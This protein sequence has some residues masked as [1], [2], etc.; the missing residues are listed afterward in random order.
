MAWRTVFFGLAAFIAS[1]FPTPVSAEPLP[2]NFTIRTNQ[3]REIGNVYG[4]STLA[5]L[6]GKP[7]KRDHSAGM[8][9]ADVR[10]HVENSGGIGFNVGGGYRWIDFDG[11]LGAWHRNRILGLHG[12]FDGREYHCRNG[13]ICDVDHFYW[14]NL[15]F[16]SLGSEWDFRINGYL[17]AGDR[18][19]E[20]M[21]EAIRFTG[22]NLIVAPFYAEAMWG[23][24]GEF[25]RKLTRVN[26][27]IKRR[28]NLDPKIY[29]AIGGYHFASRHGKDA[30]GVRF[31]LQ[32]NLHSNVTVGLR[33][34]YDSRFGGLILGQVAFA[35]GIPPR[36]TRLGPDDGPSTAIRRL[37]EFRQRQEL[38]V[39]GEGLSNRERILTDASG[40]PVPFVHV[41][42]TTG[43]GGDG[44]F[45]RPYD[46]LASVNGAGSNPGDTIVV[47]GGDGTTT[48]YDQGVTLKN[49]QS[50]IGGQ[51]L[52]MFTFG[53][54][55]VWSKIDLGRPT[56][57]NVNVGNVVTLANRNLVQGLDIVNAVSD[58]TTSGPQFVNGHGIFGSSV[59]DVRIVDV[60]VTGNDSNGILLSGS[61]GSILIDG[62]TCARNGA[63]MGGL[64]I[65][66]CID[67]TSAL[68]GDLNVTIQNSRVFDNFGDGIE[69]TSVT[70]DGTTVATIRDN[71]VFNNSEAG[72][73]A[74][75]GLDANAF[76]AVI[77]G[78]E[79]YQNA[80]QGL[81]A[82]TFAGARSTNVMISGN[83]VRANGFA[84]WAA[85][86]GIS[87]STGIDVGPNSA[88]FYALIEN[89]LVEGNAGNG[90]RVSS[91]TFNADASATVI[92][93]GNTVVGNG[94][95]YA[96]DDRAHGIL[97]FATASGGFTATYSVWLD[98]NTIS[99]NAGLAYLGTVLG[100][101]NP[102][103]TSGC[104]RLTGNTVG[105]GYVVS[106]TGGLNIGI[107]PFP[108]S[109]LATQLLEPSTNAVVPL[110][111]ITAVPTGTCGF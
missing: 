16:E 33:A 110:G 56:L 88:S 98:G 95:V 11:R 61:S 45:E 18:Q 15:G 77:S 2:F 71:V 103:G 72:I 7:L 107:G 70:L 35:I 51:L 26:A 9:F 52:G 59:Q 43:A 17:G 75:N 94:F 74:V 100:L 62:V 67:V 48:G 78:N 65:A 44:T 38:V 6:L 80:W 29:A 73:I 76:R 37:T 96:G 53:G 55:V 30:T 4:Y 34:S 91:G 108:G 106:Q 111:T 10:L 25:G 85:D 1:V 63:Q 92:I 41:N 69:V 20:Y 81:A 89:N 28:I 42:N 102:A 39:V 90:I 8:V 66:D 79:V 22:N 31:R 104:Q 46:L 99:G 23:V 19:R 3:E 60:R 12:G 24:D 68:S 86:M 84:P 109:P 47:H 49:D 5:F 32:A 97:A 50:L 40:N 93:R 54:Q 83:I 36:S 64:N 87:Q 82:G 21:L 14:I 27:F 101:G 105:G 58:G 13:M 57:T